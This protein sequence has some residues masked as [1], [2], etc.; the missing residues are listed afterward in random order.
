[1]TAWSG[2]WRH[3]LRMALGGSI[4]A[5][6]L[7]GSCQAWAAQDGLHE[8]TDAAN[9]QRMAEAYSDKEIVDL[10]AILDDAEPGS[11]VLLR[12]GTY[13]GPAV[14]RK[15]LQLR[16]ERSGEAIVIN[17][18][19]ASALTIEADDVTLSGLHIRDEA[20]KLQPSVAVAGKRAVLEDLV[21]R[22]GADGIAARDADDGTVR[23][24]EIAWA[25]EGTAMANK[26]NGIDLYNAHRWRLEGNRIR[27]VHDGIYMESSDNALV[28]DN[29]L[30]GSRYGVHGMYTTGTVI[31][32]NEGRFNVTGAMVM[33]A[34][35][36][37]VT[38]NRFAKQSE[39]VHSQ[40]ILLYDAHDSLFADNTVEGNR[41]GF[42]VEQS[43][44][45]RLER[46]R[47][48]YNF[49]GLQLLDAEGN[50]LEGNLFQGNVA[51]FAGARQSQ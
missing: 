46:N 35:G 48:I 26:G 2:G 1:M 45:N 24:T 42:Y 32:G 39:N 6:A 15:P 13:R 17:D 21:I 14:I 22:T 44:G 9:V 3:A 28:L 4:I 20:F 25:P 8:A 41:T 7:A 18:A 29:M 31:R 40:G 36:V 19:E 47:I 34:R 27:N 49:I 11:I 23:G 16:S 37:Q 30:E 10:Q 51:R 38:E 12:P 5:A 33:T 43:T 50:T